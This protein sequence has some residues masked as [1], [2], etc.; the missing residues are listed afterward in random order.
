M[1]SP[2]RKTDAPKIV[3]GITGSI[4]A[5]KTPELTRR[6]RELPAEVRCVLTP[7]GKRFVA[8]DALAAVSGARVEDALFDPEGS[9]R[10]LELA[11]WADLLLIAPCTADFLARLAHGRA[12]G[13]L[14]A[15]ALSAQIPVAVCP[16]MDAEMWEHP[17]TRRNLALVKN[18]G[19]KVWGPAK[20]PLASGKD[21]WGRLLE[22]DAI[23]E[24]CGE[25][26]SGKLAR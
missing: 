21:A 16:A 9:I 12:E 24:A 13:L 1:A 2:R 25:L 11:Q 4:A 10:H 7:T 18:D 8:P 5:Y 23:V 22:V 20:G 6:L 26:L 14:D 19:L 17:A 15:V 3:L